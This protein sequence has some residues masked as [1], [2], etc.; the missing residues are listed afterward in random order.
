MNKFILIASSFIF[1]I[2]FG[3]QAIAELPF[4]LPLKSPAPSTESNIEISDALRTELK[5]FD[6]KLKIINSEC[7][8]KRQMLKSQLS[9]TAQAAIN[10]RKNEIVNKP[11]A[12]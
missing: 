1:L 6:E 2:M 4:V 3:L 5:E 8:T 11:S 7:S 9:A 10:Y 12:K